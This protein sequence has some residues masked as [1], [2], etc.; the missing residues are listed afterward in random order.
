MDVNRSL[1]HPFKLVDFPSLAAQ[2]KESEYVI[3]N[4]ET[5]LDTFAVHNIPLEFISSLGYHLL[6]MHDKLLVCL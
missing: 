2:V 4:R 6:I 1:P 5:K 3:T